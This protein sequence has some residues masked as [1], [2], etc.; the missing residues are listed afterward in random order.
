MTIRPARSDEHA[1]LLAIWEQ[2]VR[3]T[4]GF[5]S[6]Q[7]IRQLQPIVRDAALPNLDLWVVCDDSDAPL[8]WMGLDQNKLEALFI[9]PSQ[10]RRGHGKRLLDHARQR[11]GPLL[12]DVNEQN[13][14]AVAFY[15]GNGFSVVSR[16]ETDSL[17]LPFPLLHLGEAASPAA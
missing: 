17:G 10:F 13:P 3:A 11:K 1:A 12:V 16:S 4:H 9:A 7:D 2:S 6:E 8:G 5:L 15:L 14:Q